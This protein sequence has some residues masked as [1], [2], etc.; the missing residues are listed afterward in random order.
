MEISV[1]ELAGLEKLTGSANFHLW[2]DEMM[3]F[4][5]IYGLGSF[6]RGCDTQPDPS[7]ANRKEIKS[8]DKQSKTLKFV[9]YCTVDSS[10]KSIL[11][12]YVVDQKVGRCSATNMT[13]APLQ[14][15][16]RY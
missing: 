6:V 2:K 15:L 16:I 11:S 1:K 3:T 12:A 13:N 7:T 5:S 4:F 14:L 10:I 8:W 9:L